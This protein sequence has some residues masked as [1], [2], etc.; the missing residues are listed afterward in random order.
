MKGSRDADRRGAPALFSAPFMFRHAAHEADAP[1]V[2]LSGVTVRYE[3]TPAIEQVDL[4]VQAGERLAVIGPNGAGK[5]TLFHT[6]AGLLEPDS[7]SVS[8]FGQPPRRHACIAYLVQR[9][10]IDW[11]F[12]A[13][14]RDVV[15]MGR[16]RQIGFFRRPAGRDWRFVDEC[17][18][19]VGLAALANR[20]IDELSGGQQQRL[21][22]ARA[23]AQ[24]AAILL[25]DEPFTG[26]DAAT[27]HDVLRLLADLSAHKTTVLVSTHDLD[28]AAA[29]FERIVLLHRRIIADGP[30]ADALSAANLTATFGRE[31]RPFRLTDGYLVFSGTCDARKTEERGSANP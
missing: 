26:V 16:V 18:E 31:A 27:E 17:L 21:F 30:P 25:L 6:V 2:A 4:T 1:A 24:E 13:T 10:A 7:G 12:P 29:H 20:R 8:V 19:R 22:I 14:V 9:P 15:M 28:I 5:T 23:L 3:S 11:H